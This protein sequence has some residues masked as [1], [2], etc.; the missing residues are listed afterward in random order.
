MKKWIII[1]VVLALLGAGGY[2]FF[3]YRSAQTAAASVTTIETETLQTG[4]LEA[5]ISAIGKVRARQSASLYW[6]TTGMV[7]SVN[8]KVGESVQ[9]N[10]E[11]ARLAQSSL[12][13]SIILAQA[14]LFSAEQA[15]DDLTTTADEARVT[16]MQ[17]IVTYQEAVRD[18]QYSLDNFSVPSN[19]S[20]MTPVEAVNAMQA[21]LDKA[22]T[23]FEPYKYLS[24]GNSTRE[25][26][27]EDLALAQSDYD[28]AI[29]W[30]QYE[31][32]LEVA[33]KNLSKAQA[34]Y[35]KW[36]DGPL[37]G[38]V[39]AAKARIEAQKATLA[40]A[41]VESPFA[42]TVTEVGPLVGD[43][44][45]TGD[46]AFRLDDLS[47]LYIDVQV[48]EIDINQ[49]QAGQSVTL[50][51]DAIRGHSYSGVVTQVA[52]NGVDSSGVVDYQVTVELSNPDA[53]VRP[54][55]TSE[56]NIIVA[57]R[58]ETL[59]VPNQSLRAENG[60]QVVY[61][62]QPDGTRK[63]VE[64]TVGI[65]NDSHSELLTGDLK[66]GDVVVLNPTDTT[67]QDEMMGPG[68]PFGMPRPRNNNNNRNNSGGGQGQP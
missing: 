46:L 59:L 38:E 53:Q 48:S 43:K 16:A 9:A 31:T 52:M 65:A 35:E 30:L 44:I 42:A 6:G 58:D 3:V 61:V 54:G 51:L 24:S 27:K 13:Q 60:V 33:Q 18:A 63:R 14:E 21:I 28:S 47:K 32:N 34:D 56:V 36:K 22:R 17:N 26:L 1:V 39:D 57:S 8:V 68:G 45:S 40:Q 2:Y 20:K 7:E 66:A 15:L 25:N 41:W 49:V 50:T 55:M 64:V 29:K 5:V 19:M 4:K 11:L 37:Q 12:P 67:A 62:V 10:E 23:A